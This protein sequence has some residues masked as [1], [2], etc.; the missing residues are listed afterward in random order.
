MIFDYSQFIITK[1]SLG[2]LS[3][4]H[5]STRATRGGG[6]LFPGSVPPLKYII[7]IWLIVIPNEADYY[8]NIYHSLYMTPH[9]LYDS[10][11][12]SHSFFLKSKALKQLKVRCSDL[13]KQRIYR[14]SHLLSQGVEAMLSKGQSLLISCETG[15]PCRVGEQATTKEVPQRRK[16]NHETR[17]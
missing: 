8:I 5:F 6:W 15:N 16:A 2:Y 1:G 12:Y 9:D 17:K 4:M 7:Y 10:Y 3:S 13:W 11:D 14:R